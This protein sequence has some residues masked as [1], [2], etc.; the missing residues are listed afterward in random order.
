MRKSNRGRW[1]GR[2]KEQ[3][4]QGNVVSKWRY[5]F[6]AKKVEI[7]RLSTTKQISW[8]WLRR[9]MKEDGE[10]HSWTSFIRVLWSTSAA[11]PLLQ[12]PINTAT[13]GIL[14][15]AQILLMC[16]FRESTVEY[17]L[18]LSL[19]F[20]YISN[21]DYL[22]KTEFEWKKCVVCANILKAIR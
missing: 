21:V 5:V 4:L 2:R 9:T 18:S 12:F 1:N 16:L 8:P 13:E 14:K 15:Q 17:N 6:S 19:F 22:W 10:A 20:T 3:M 11:W 7:H